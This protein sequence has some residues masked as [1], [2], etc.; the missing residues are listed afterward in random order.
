[1][2][3]EEQLIEMD[4]VFNEPLSDRSKPVPED[5]NPPKQLRGEDI[6]L[7]LERLDNYNAHY[8]ARGKDI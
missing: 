4:N 5:W 3:T 7:S 1:M 8:H 2:P 6:K